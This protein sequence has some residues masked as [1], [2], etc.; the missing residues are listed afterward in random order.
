MVEFVLGESREGGWRGGK[1][2]YVD[3]GRGLRC[4]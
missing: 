1:D 2:I 3:K 4:G